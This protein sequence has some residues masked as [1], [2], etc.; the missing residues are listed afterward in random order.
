MSTTLPLSSM[1]LLSAILYLNSLILL[2]KLMT[3]VDLLPPSVK[4][5]Q[6]NRFFKN[7]F[8]LLARVIAVTFCVTLATS[9]AARL[10]A[11]P[12]AAFQICLQV[13]I[14]SSL[15][16]DG[17]AIAGQVIIAC[18]FAEKDYEKAKVVATRVLQFVAATQPINSLAFVFDGVNFGAS[19]FIYFAYSMG[20]VSV[21]SITSLFLLWKSHGFVGIWFGLTIFMG[22][23]AFS[24]IL[25]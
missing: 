11:T 18:A 15:L 5:L 8:L 3:K 16:F 4:D 2:C 12:M 7:G 20:L 22:L 17:L 14:T 13:W 24:G 6:F 9:L 10:G 19:D 1:S 23:R 21:V 25:R